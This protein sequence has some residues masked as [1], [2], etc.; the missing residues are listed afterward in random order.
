MSLR[1]YVH[2]RQIKSVKYTWNLFQTPFPVELTLDKLAQLFPK[3]CH[4]TNW[5][6][7]KYKTSQISLTDKSLPSFNF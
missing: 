3:V 4:G 5:D 2:K 7:F 6:M 1:A